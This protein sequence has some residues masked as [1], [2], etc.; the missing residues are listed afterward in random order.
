MSAD[1]WSKCPKCHINK[2]PAKISNYGKVSEEEYL[3][4]STVEIEPE[5]TLREDYGIYMDENGI[6]NISYEAE[7]GDCGW[8]FKFSV[9]KNAL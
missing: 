2:K 8:T 1:A 4:K 7:C 9:E 5:E 3:K 6:L